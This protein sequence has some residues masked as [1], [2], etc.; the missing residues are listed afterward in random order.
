MGTRSIL[1]NRQGLAAKA[2]CSSARLLMATAM[3]G[4]VAMLILANR[5][6]TS[7]S[8]TGLATPFASAEMQWVRLFRSSLADGQLKV[9]CFTHTLLDL[10]EPCPWILSVDYPP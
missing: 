4:G 7:R 1:S 3:D 8:L 2:L 10:L 6:F 5:Y 9:N